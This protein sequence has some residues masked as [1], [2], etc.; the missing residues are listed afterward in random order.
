[1]ADLVRRH[2]HAVHES[3]VLR[4]EFV[5]EADPDDAQWKIAAYES[6][7]G[8]RLWHA[9]ATA[10]VPVAIVQALLESLDA[11]DPAGLATSSNISEAHVWEATRPLFDTGWD[12]TIDGRFIRWQAPGD[13]PAGV[14]FD[15]FAANFQQ[16]DLPAWTFWGD[17]TADAP[18]WALHFSTHAAATVLQDVAGEAADRYAEPV[19]SAR[20]QRRLRN[21]P[22]V[23]ASHAAAPARRR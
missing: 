6:P 14:Q 10:T 3:L 7:V 21:A 2:H 1:M 15:A 16:S 8:E 5:H 11:A 23:P 4:A 22:P 18:G 12:H 13:H 20:H 19:A 9:T 17:G